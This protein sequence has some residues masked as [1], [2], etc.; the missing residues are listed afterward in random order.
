MSKYYALEV[1]NGVA[2]LFI[3]G[4]ITSMPWV[5]SDVSS[6]SLVRELMALDAAEI[7]VHI[8]SYGGEVAEGLAIYNALVASP[9]KVTT[10]CEGF[11][12]SAASF[13]F[14]AGDERIMRDASMLFVHNAWTSVSGD[15]EA[16]RHE[17]EALEKVSRR[18]MEIFLNAGLSI[19][20]ADLQEMFDTETWLT[21]QECLEIGFA[22]TIAT[23]K[24]LTRASQSARK[25]AFEL[26]NSGLVNTA[27]MMNYIR[28]KFDGGNSSPT[29][30]L[31]DAPPA[32]PEPEPAPEQNPKNIF[33]ALR[34]R[35]D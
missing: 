2:D 11:A 22:T 13:I 24:A 12:C 19:G 32:P 5:E 35:K 30:P 29:E 15:A 27:T 9:A 7:N 20:E 25:A 17:A 31:P 6:Y 1:R 34:S 10:I 28:A 33:E 3:F 4:D 18:T 16:L 21:P 23:N 14:M 26:L 8:N